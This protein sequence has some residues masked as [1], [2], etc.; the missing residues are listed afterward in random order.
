MNGSKVLFRQDLHCQHG[1]KP[2]TKDTSKKRSQSKQT[3]TSTVRDKKTACTSKLTVRVYAKTATYVKKHGYSS[4]THNCHVDMYH[5][6]NHPVGSAHVLSFRPI[7]PETVRI[8]CEYFKAGHSAASAHRTHEMMLLGEDDF[9][10]KIADRAINPSLSDV[11]HLFQN[12]REMEM[13]PPDGKELF[14]RLELEVVQY[15]EMHAIHGGQ[16]LLQKYEK[17]SQALILA[18]CT[19]L[20]V[21]AHT[22]LCQS[23]EYIF[24]DA[25]ANLDGHNVAAFVL[26][27]SHCG[28]GIPLGVIITS[29][30]TQHTLTRAFQCL[31]QVLPHGAFY[32]RTIENGP[33][34]VITDDSS[35]ERSAIQSIWPDCTLLLCTFHFLQ[36][37]WTWLWDSKNGIKK[38]DRSQLMILL[39]ELVFAES[40]YDLLAKYQLLLE[41]QCAQQYPK[42]LK[43]IGH[44]WES[45]KEWA[46][47]YR[48]KLIIRGNNTNN[49]AEIGMR[50]IKDLVFC[51]VKAY[52]LVQMF[53]FFTKNID[54]YYCTRLLSLG[55][56]RLDCHIARRYRGLSASSIPKESIVKI[57]NEQFE[58]PSKTQEGMTYVVDIALG[59]CSCP[60][61]SNGSACVHQAAV[62]LHYC[63]DS[64]NSAPALSID[65]RLRFVELALGKDRMHQADFYA[66]LHQKAIENSAA[67]CSTKASSVQGQVL[68]QQKEDSN[69]LV[70]TDDVDSS[71]ANLEANLEQFKDCPPLIDGHSTSWYKDDET[72]PDQRLCLEVPAVIL[73]EEISTILSALN[74][75]IDDIRER[76]LIKDPQFNSGILR[77]CEQYNKALSKTYPTLTLASAFHRF[78]SLL[79]KN[80]FKQLLVQDLGNASMFNQQQLEGGNLV[81]VAVR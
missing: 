33:T 36:S 44:V 58:V 8:F 63:T 21:R 11:N 69:H 17:D 60:A 40:E 23:G 31:L 45:R 75:V 12:W 15:N 29:D 72:P 59:I 27:T 79:Q 54:D 74:G 14:E 38:N 4:L 49:Y 26:S 56:N 28:G 42:F 2:A 43:R 50:I 62:S 80:L 13:G 16:A 51:R 10:L 7:S 19:P 20:M 37:K 70:H 67:T 30:E 46:L 68:V 71:L 1:F 39:K 81:N 22:L 73:N 25:T 78:N 64:I 34:V 6:H 5:N 41:N 35:T 53:Y 76:V 55:H 18:I 52:N 66:S 47:C 61:G 32:G 24:C 65:S 48:K 77:F 3:L 57:T 9:E